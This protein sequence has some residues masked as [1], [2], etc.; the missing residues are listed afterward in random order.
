L[1]PHEIISLKLNFNLATNFNMPF[2]GLCRI[3]T[4]FLDNKFLCGIKLVIIILIPDGRKTIH[5][6]QY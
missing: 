2:Y 5:N 6:L 4:T 1:N 3:N